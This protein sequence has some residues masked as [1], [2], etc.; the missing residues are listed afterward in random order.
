MSKSRRTTRTVRLAGG[1]LQTAGLVLQGQIGHT[2]IALELD[3][4]NRAVYAGDPDRPNGYVVM[5]YRATFTPSGK[6]VPDAGT[7]RSTEEAAS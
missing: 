3:D 1:P 4:G 6:V 5:S 2:T 7:S